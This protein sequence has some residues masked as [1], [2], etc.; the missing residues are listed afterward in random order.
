MMPYVMEKIMKRWK[1]KKFEE[2]VRTQPCVICGDE[3]EP[4]HIKGVGQL[5]GV[6]L[7][8]PS[9]AVMPMCHMHHA[10]LHDDPSMWDAQWEWALRTLGEAIEQGVLK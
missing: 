2:W 5:S 7:K 3:A 1:S 8:A 10:N 6:G 9:W 4:H